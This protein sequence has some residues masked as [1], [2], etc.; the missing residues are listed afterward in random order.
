MSKLEN[1]RNA[2]A[3]AS[4]KIIAANILFRSEE[5]ETGSRSLESQAIIKISSNRRMGHTTTLFGVARKFFKK[6]L[7]VFA[8]KH[9]ESFFVR[10]KGCSS[11]SCCL[12]SRVD[13]HILGDHDA[14]LVDNASYIS[15]DDTDKI[16]MVSGY[17][18]SKNKN[19]CLIMIG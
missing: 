1:Y 18:Y 7:F 11:D 4:E 8:N 19:F 3:E 9:Q 2:F 10:E 6:P 17:M 15:N 5:E 13:T 12:A 14:I 16:K